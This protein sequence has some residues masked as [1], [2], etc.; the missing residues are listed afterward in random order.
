MGGVIY[1]LAAY[2]AWGLMPVYWKALASVPAAEI[3]AHRVVWTA[4]FGALLLTGL[5][6]WSEFRSA[7]ADPRERLVLAASGILIGVNWVIFIGAVNRDQILEASFGYYLNP[8]LNVVLGV[9]LLGERLARPQVIGVAIAAI[10]VTALGVELGGLPWVSLTLAFTFG[11]Y[12]LL[13]K[14]GRTRPIPALAVETTLLAPLAL[15]YVAGL[16]GGALTDGT[17]PL[18]ALLVGAGVAT[19]LPLLWFQ[20][21]A[22]RLRLSTLGLFQYLAPSLSFLLAVFVYGEPFTRTQAFAFA[23]IWLA[24]AIATAHGLR[25]ASRLTPPGAGHRTRAARGRARARARAPRGSDDPPRPPGP[26]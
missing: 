19:A 8:L 18:R 12:G 11:L 2:G 24:L 9:I 4:A 17:P 20:S 14:V 6:R 7:L 21:A 10:G 22:R 16:G 5:G 1:A 23:C 13:H 25:S 3:L 26:S 15:I